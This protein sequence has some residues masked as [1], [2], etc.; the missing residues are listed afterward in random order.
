V[1]VK[2]KTIIAAITVAGLLFS[3]I[4]LQFMEVAKADEY[5]HCNLRVNSPSDSA[6]YK[7]F[8]PLSVMFDFTRGNDTYVVSVQAHATYSID[9]N[10]STQITLLPTWHA[11]FD[12]NETV[13]SSAA[14]VTL[15]AYENVSI[16][17]LLEGKHSLS[18]NVQGGYNLAGA[19]LVGFNQTFSPIYFYVGSNSTP[20]PSTTPSLSLSPSPTIPE[21]PLTTL[22]IAV[23]TA[24]TL[25]G[26]IFVSRKRRLWQEERES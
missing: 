21:F 9:G 6:Y 26:A 16:G 20:S 8:M 22:T 10:Y 23:L 15:S 19:A 11:N 13:T 4:G 2:R 1:A 14:T 25:V 3:L 5:V 17:Y 12:S 24:T 18:I 7:D